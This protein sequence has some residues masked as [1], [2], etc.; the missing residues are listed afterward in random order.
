MPLGFER[1]NE[2]TKRPNELINFIKPLPGPDEELAKDFLER[3]AAIC[4]PIMKANHISVMSLEEYEPNREFIGRNFNNGE[5]IQ[6]VL[7]AH[8]GE[9]VPFKHVQMVMMHEL[10]HCKQMNHSKAFWKVRDSYAAELHTLWGRGYT[11][12]GLWGRG[13]DMSGQYE[14]EVMPQAVL[15]IDRLCGGTYRSR[16]RQRKRSE[17][18]PKLTYKE[19]K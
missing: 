12:E 2:R 16:G 7:K 8:T 13:R 1:V 11:G 10:A 14:T 3:V 19:K 5:V 18:K 17:A 4:Y 6:L 15:D 9:W